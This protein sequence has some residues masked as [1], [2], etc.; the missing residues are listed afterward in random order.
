MLEYKISHPGITSWNKN[1]KEGALMHA[2]RDLITTEE[3]ITA[4]EMGKA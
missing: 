2:I 3:I 1:E 4:S